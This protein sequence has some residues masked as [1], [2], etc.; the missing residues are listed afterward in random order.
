[1]RYLSDFQLNLIKGISHS[2]ILNSFLGGSAAVVLHNLDLLSRPVHDL[3]FVT[4]STLPA[5]DFKDRLY[6]LAE[7][8]NPAAKVRE[9]YKDSS[10]VFEM[11]D[12]RVLART[13]VFRNKENEEILVDFFFPKPKAAFLNTK[14]VKLNLPNTSTRPPVVSILSLPSIIKAKIDYINS[15][16]YRENSL[17][18][19]RDLIYMGHP[20]GCKFLVS[21]LYL[22]DVPTKSNIK[23][24]PPLIEKP[25]G[26]D[27]DDKLPW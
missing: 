10:G 12:E 6:A 17:K 8:L 18:H 7:S 11:D 2:R 4:L 21:Y 26:Y 20:D 22:A 9:I 1:M 13:F 3:D 19:I 24:K 27:L 23:G 5:H 16:L 14:R 15:T 25:E